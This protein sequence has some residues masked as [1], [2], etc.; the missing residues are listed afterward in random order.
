VSD[1]KC[2]LELLDFLHKT[3]DRAQTHLLETLVDSSLQRCQLGLGSFCAG[4][5][6]LDDVVEEQ[7]VVVQ[8][9]GHVDV[10]ECLEHDLLLVALHDVAFD[11]ACRTDGRFDGTHTVVLMLLVGQL[12]RTEF[13]CVH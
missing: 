7:D 1:L 8:E 11:D 5:Q 12:F 4:E 9:L 10:D 3:G 6:V 13:E 2:I